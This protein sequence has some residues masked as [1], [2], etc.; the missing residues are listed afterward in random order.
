MT[1][2]DRI[3]ALE[4]Q[5]TLLAQTVASLVKRAALEVHA[6]QL[7]AERRRETSVG[8]RELP[9]RNPNPVIVP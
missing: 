7:R 9:M 2:T 5:V 4:M 3:A 1:D 8:T 6:E